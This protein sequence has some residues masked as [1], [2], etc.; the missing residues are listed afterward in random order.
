MAMF[1]G[2]E[3]IINTNKYFKNTRGGTLSWWANG[4]DSTYQ[5]FPGGSVVKNP[6]ANAGDMGLISGPGRSHVP[7]GN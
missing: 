1:I 4:Q 3:E 5:G 2:R 6:L 7:R